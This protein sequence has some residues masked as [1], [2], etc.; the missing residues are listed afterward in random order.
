MVM[1]GS[2]LPLLPSP[3]CFLSR[4]RPRPRAQTPLLGT[5][6][7]VLARSLGKRRELQHIKKAL[8]KPKT[9]AMPLH[10]PHGVLTCCD[11]ETETV[12]GQLV[13]QS[14]TQSISQID[15]KRT[16]RPVRSGPK[17]LVK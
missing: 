16:P 13:S 5:G 17:S 8:A 6:T 15:N 1:V 7:V 11:N 3:S 2:F 10:F 9:H 14:V 4:P 12:Y